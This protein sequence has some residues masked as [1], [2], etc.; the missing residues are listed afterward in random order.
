VIH[1][2]HVVE[3]NY[4]IDG[5]KGQVVEESGQNDV[6]QV[7]DPEGLMDLL[8]DV[9]VPDGHDLLENDAV[10]EVLAMF[11]LGRHLGI[12]WYVIHKST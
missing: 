2:L 11:Q 4:R 6:L 5:C 9:S 8:E 1:D 3:I 12:I 10:L 7:L